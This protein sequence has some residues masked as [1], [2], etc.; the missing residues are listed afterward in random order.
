MFSRHM[1]HVSISQS[2]IST[3]L[4]I[5]NHDDIYLVFIL[6]TFF[7]DYKKVMFISVCIIIVC[8]C[9]IACVHVWCRGVNINVNGPLFHSSPYII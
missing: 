4:F 7:I 1:G 3:I 9:M 5:F 8:V 2:F 6:Q